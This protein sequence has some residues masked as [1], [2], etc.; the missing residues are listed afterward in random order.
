MFFFDILFTFPFCSETY[1]GKESVR[2]GRTAHGRARVA[3]L[4]LFDDISSLK[5]GSQIGVEEKGKERQR[6]REREGWCE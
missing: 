5:T 2:D 1:V 6:E 3:A 4:G